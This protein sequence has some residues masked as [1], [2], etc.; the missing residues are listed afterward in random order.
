VPSRVD[1]THQH[2]DQ[3]L[4]IIAK[5]TEPEAADK[6]QAGGSDPPKKVRRGRGRGHKGNIL[7]PNGQ[8]K[9]ADRSSFSK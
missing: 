4:L 2:T 5:G 8:L 9:M 3:R 1:H 6:G 7:K